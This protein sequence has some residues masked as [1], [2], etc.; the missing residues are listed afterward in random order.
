M[1]IAHGGLVGKT[2]WF[3]S[4][5]CGLP[6]RIAACSTRSE[7]RVPEVVQPFSA[8]ARNIPKAKPAQCGKYLITCLSSQYV[9]CTEWHKQLRELI[10]AADGADAAPFETG[11]RFRV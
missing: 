2:T 11:Q 3:T 4:D 10:A 7:K 9:V 1:A 6:W 8:W 5:Y